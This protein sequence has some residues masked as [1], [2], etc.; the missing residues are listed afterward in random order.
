MILLSNGTMCYTLGNNV[1]IRKMIVSIKLACDAN[2]RCGV[3]P[4]RIESGRYEGLD[5]ESRTCFNCC[6][7]VADEIHMLL[8]CLAYDMIRLP[9]SRLSGMILPWNSNLTL[10]LHV[11]IC[12]AVLPTSSLILLT[13]V[14]M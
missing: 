3:A 5:I 11:G 8:Q 12:S 9:L 1:F 13:I 7:Q 10:Y 2:F 6:N 14:G 4:I